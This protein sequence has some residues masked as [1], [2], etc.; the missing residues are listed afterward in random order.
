MRSSRNTCALPLSGIRA[1]EYPS[2]YSG[3]RENCLPGRGCRN[4]AFLPIADAADAARNRRRH[5]VREIRALADAPELCR[6]ACAAREFEARGWRLPL[7]AFRSLLAGRAA[8]ALLGN[9][10]WQ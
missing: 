1:A 3:R 6:R 7:R 9:T 4:R 10:G 5:V 2:T 8:L